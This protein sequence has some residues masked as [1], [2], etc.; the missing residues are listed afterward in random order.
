MADGVE[1]GFIGAI[2]GALSAKAF[3]A[4][5]AVAVFAGFSVCLF[6]SVFKC[7]YGLKKRLWFLILV[8]MFYAFLKARAS[9]TGENDF[10]PLLLF[11][12]LTLFLPVFFIREKPQINRTGNETEREFVRVLDDRIKCADVS[13]NPPAAI[14]KARA[15]DRADFK[16]EVL[17]AKPKTPEICD[18]PD[19][20][21]VKN[22]LQ[23]LEPA[24][25]SYADR[26]QIRELELSIYEAEKGE[27]SEEARRKI[28]EGLGNLLK[29]MAR[30][31][32]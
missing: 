31:G 11:L 24:L 26:R 17:K 32:V 13:E 7:G 22:V 9:V 8:F 18:K 30:H 2:F 3:L 25:L 12:G 23:R 4:L 21:H 28:N 6:L 29:I 14:L 19:F 16:T 20:S 5:S 15:D 1:F 10:S 27:Y